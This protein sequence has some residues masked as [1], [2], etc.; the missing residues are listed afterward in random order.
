MTI[1]IVLLKTRQ[2]N[3]FDPFFKVKQGSSKE[4]IIYF[5][6]NV[7]GHRIIRFTFFIYNKISNILFSFPIFQ[8]GIHIFSYSLELIFHFLRFINTEISSYSIILSAVRSD[9]IAS[10]FRSKN[11]CRTIISLVFDTGVSKSLI[12]IA[13]ICFPAFAYRYNNGSTK[14]L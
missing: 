1:F 2:S 10:I 4:T 9:F 6:L 12:S 3:Y 8:H 7:Y 13:D 14:I 11:P 5:L